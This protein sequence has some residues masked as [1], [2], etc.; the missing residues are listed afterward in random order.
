MS[1]WDQ[2]A[3]SVDSISTWSTPKKGLGKFSKIGGMSA[4][5]FSQTVAGNGA[6]TDEYTLK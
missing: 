2:L 1:S 4:G 5:S 3:R 6:Y